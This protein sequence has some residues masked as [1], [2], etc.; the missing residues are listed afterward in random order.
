MA[1]VS[2]NIKVDETLKKDAQELFAELGMNLTTAVN[3]FLRQA[4]RCRA[5][6]FPIRADDIP[7]EEIKEAIREVEEMKK[8]PSFVKG[9]TD[10]DEMMRELLA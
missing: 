5:I 1:V 2:T 9:Y 10:V 4:V 7:N 3:V 8:N 6:P